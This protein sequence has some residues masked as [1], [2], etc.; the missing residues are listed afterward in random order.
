MLKDNHIQTFLA[1]TGRLVAFLGLSA[2]VCMYSFGVCF[3]DHHDDMTA[4]GHLHRHLDNCTAHGLE[5]YA[6]ALMAS[7]CHQ[8]HTHFFHLHEAAPI[9]LQ[10]QNKENRSC[11][12]GLDSPSPPYRSKNSLSVG[13]HPIKGNMAHLYGIQSA[14]PIL[15]GQ[16]LPLLI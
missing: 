9:L 13:M 14:S 6:Q 16:T 7:C 11:K 1:R 5:T 4:P 2:A 8:R 10:E 12:A 15:P 3:T